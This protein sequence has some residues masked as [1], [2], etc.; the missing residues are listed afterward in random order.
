MSMENFSTKGQVYLKAKRQHNE[1]KL[2]RTTAPTKQKCVMG[3]QPPSLR[4]LLF[5]CM[6]QDENYFIKSGNTLS[7]LRIEDV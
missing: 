5:N 3:R 6:V 4:D 1:V 7:L 2:N